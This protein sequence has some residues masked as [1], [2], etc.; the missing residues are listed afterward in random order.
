MGLP[1]FTKML[2]EVIEMSLCDWT[3]GHGMRGRILYRDP[4]P[5]VEELEVS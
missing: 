3:Y 1:L 5:T 2:S 4:E